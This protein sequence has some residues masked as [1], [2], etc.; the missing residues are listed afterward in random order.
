[1]LVSA[2]RLDG[3]ECVFVARH[4][5]ISSYFTATMDG[6]GVELHLEP[7]LGCY[8]WDFERARNDVEK[9]VLEEIAERLSIHPE[10]VLMQKLARLKS[11][12]DPELPKYLQWASRSKGR[13]RARF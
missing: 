4:A 10:Q 3:K 6:N 12:A 1:M 13:S 9:A 2:A 8:P 11:V 7:G 5:S